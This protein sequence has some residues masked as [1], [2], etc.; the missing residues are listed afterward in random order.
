MGFGVCWINISNVSIFQ[1][2]SPTN[3]TQSRHCGLRKTDFG[4][5]V[6]SDPCIVSVDSRPCGCI[7]SEQTQNT[8][9]YVFN[10]LEKKKEHRSLVCNDRTEPDPTCP[11]S[12]SRSNRLVTIIGRSEWIPVRTVNRPCR[13][14]RVVRK[15]F[16]TFFPTRV[17]SSGAGDSFAGSSLNYQGFLKYGFVTVYVL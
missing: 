6:T 8:S 3:T 12:S 10:V 2:P 16:F 13:K 9:R 11:R 15:L 5:Y 17:G 14:T 7:K 4:S 1:P